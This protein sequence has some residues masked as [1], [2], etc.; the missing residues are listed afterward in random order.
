MRR[1]RAGRG[2][3]WRDAAV[4]REGRGGRAERRRPL[5]VPARRP[6]RA[7][8]GLG[9]G[10]GRLGGTGHRYRHRDLLRVTGAG[11]AAPRRTFRKYRGGPSAGP[12]GSGGAR[13]P[14]LSAGRFPSSPLSA[15]RGAPAAPPSPAGRRRCSLGRGRSGSGPAAARLRPRS[16]PPRSAPGPEVTPALGRPRCSARCGVGLP[17]GA[18]V[19]PG[20]GGGRRGAEVAVWPRWAAAG[21]EG[22]GGL[23]AVLGLLALF[24]VFDYFLP[25]RR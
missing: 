3:L 22:S 20:C 12:S 15:A 23:A 16:A 14:G 24:C 10:G 1:R 25:A 21:R 9:A 17:A 6:G 4:S 19:A 2:G 7:A 11:K 8:R 5:H 18:A 13:C